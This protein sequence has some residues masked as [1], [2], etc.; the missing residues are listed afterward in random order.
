MTN[1]QIEFNEDL[2]GFIFTFENGAT[3]QTQYTQIEDALHADNGEWELERYTEYD[4]DLTPEQED[5]V[6]KYIEN[7]PFKE[8]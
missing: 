3:A 5:E 7:A 6:N 2:N 1:T 8:Q 4:T